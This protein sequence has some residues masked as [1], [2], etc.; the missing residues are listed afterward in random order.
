MSARTELIERELKDLEEQCLLMK[1]I[2]FDNGFQAA[3]GRL[4]N[5]EFEVREA[6][7]LVW[8]MDTKGV[9]P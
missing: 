1:R 3:H 5:A 6:W 2:L 4:A 7:K 8:D 9:A